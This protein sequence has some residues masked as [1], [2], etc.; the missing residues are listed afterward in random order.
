MKSIL[1]KPILTEKANADSESRNRFAFVVNRNCNKLEIKSA[2]EKFYG[3]NVESVRT[4]R[5]GGGLARKKYTSRGVSDE[6]TKLWKKAIITV[7]EGQTID[8]YENI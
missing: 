8:L 2:V 4:M 5:Y 6:G 3:V 1:I 7:A